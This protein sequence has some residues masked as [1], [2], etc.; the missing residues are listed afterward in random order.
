MSDPVVLRNAEAT[1]CTPGQAVL[2]WHRANGIVPIVRSAN[3]SRQRE[4]LAAVAMPPL[5]PA[6]VAQLDALDPHDE[7]ER[8]IRDSDT[9]EEL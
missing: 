2:R 6:V 1:A 9:H 5:P 8:G 4:N 3:P 7:G